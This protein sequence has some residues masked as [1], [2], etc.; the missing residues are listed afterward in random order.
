[1]DGSSQELARRYYNPTAFR[2]MA[3]SN[4]FL[5]SLRA[6]GFVV[7]DGAEFGYVKIPRRKNRRLDGGQNRRE[8][9]PGDFTAYS[10]RDGRRRSAQCPQKLG[11]SA[12]SLPSPSSARPYPLS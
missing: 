7:T 11:A 5:K 10:A 4:G 1:M 2:R 8:L 12:H 3:G 6:V 9:Q